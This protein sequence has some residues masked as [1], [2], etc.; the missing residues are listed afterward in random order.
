MPGTAGRV[1]DPVHGYI[2]FTRIERTLF[3]HAVAQ[4]LRVI[5][6]SAAAHLVY[7]EMRVSRCAHSLGAIY[8]ASRFL[9]RLSVTPAGVSESRSWQHAARWWTLAADWGSATEPESTGR[10][11]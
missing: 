9:R 3:D 6:Q 11:G 4:R 8:V 10:R 7:P 1:R 5:S 2:A